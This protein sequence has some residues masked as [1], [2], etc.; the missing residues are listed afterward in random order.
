[1]IL[2]LSLCRNI[3]IIKIIEI[4]GAAERN[5]GNRL[6]IVDHFMQLANLTDIF[7]SI[8]SNVHIREYCAVN[9]E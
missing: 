4:I 2:S 3:S 1:M 7:S 6:L 5:C 8:G 9:E